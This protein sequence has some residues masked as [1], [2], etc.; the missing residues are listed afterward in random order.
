VVLRGADRLGRG[1][2][3]GIIAGGD[4]GWPSSHSRTSLIEAPP[5]FY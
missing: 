2:P 3:G 5:R 4:G 1:P